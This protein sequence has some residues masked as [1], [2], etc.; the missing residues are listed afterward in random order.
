LLKIITILLLSYPAAQA[1]PLSA[2]QYWSQVCSLREAQINQVLVNLLRQL[3]EDKAEIERLK[4]VK[5]ES[6]PNG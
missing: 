4:Q 6:K 3:D 1:Q 5:Q 2:E